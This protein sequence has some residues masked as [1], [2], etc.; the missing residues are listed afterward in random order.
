L[1]E[2]KAWTEIRRK[3]AELA[4]TQQKA[5]KTKKATGKHR[6]AEGRKGCTLSR[7]TCMGY[8]GEEIVKGDTFF[9]LDVNEDVRQAL[10][11]GVEWYSKLK[12][13]PKGTETARS[14]VLDCARSVC[15]VLSSCAHAFD[16]YIMTDREISDYEI[17][18]EAKAACTSPSSSS[19]S[20]SSGD[21]GAR[22]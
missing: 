20:S 8:A 15:C 11:K 1:T 2:H 19:S 5:G 7:A 21:T 14:V 22:E 9:C 13:T 4:G 3:L 12:E 10:S 6:K 17:V 16:S 18:T